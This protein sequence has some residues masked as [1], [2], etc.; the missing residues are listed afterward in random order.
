MTTLKKRI[1][2][3]T[4]LLMAT[5]VAVQFAAACAPNTQQASDEYAVTTDY[6]NEVT[7]AAS[8]P[9]TYY[10][11]HGEALSSVDEPQVQGYDFEGWTYSADG[12]GEVSFPLTPSRDMAI[13][14]QWSVQMLN[15]TFDF[16]EADANPVV[17]E[18]EYGSTVTPLSEEQI[19]EYPGYKFREWRLE[20]GNP[21]N[22]A[23]P[24]RSNVTYYAAWLSDDT[25]I[26]NVNF[27]ANYPG[28]EAIPS[29][30][31][32]AGEEFDVDGLPIVS[33]PGYEFIGWAYS[34]DATSDD[35]IDMTEFS[36]TSD[37]TMYAVWE[38]ETYTITFRKNIP[39][40][41]VVNDLIS[42][43]TVRSDEQVT[44]PDDP[45]REGFI[46]VGWFDAAKGGQKVEFPAAVTSS[47][48]YYAHWK[49]PETTPENN[50]FEAEY[51]YFNPT[52]YF[53]GYSGGVTGT[54][55]IVS[56]LGGTYDSHN[57]YHVS[58]MFKRGA[59]I[60][61]V[62]NSDRDINGAKLYAKLGAEMTLGVTLTPEG[63]Y[64]YRFVV[65]GVDVDYGSITLPDTPVDPNAAMP[66]TRLQEYF[67]G[68]V[69][70]KKGENIIQLI[71]NNDTAPG[72]TMTATAPTVDYVRL[73]ADGAT[74]TW[75]PELDNFSNK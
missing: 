18:V 48:T 39:G 29:Q 31:V 50:I 2:A 63:Q 34:A 47:S 75:S 57:D 15:V 71:T 55:A 74:L 68:T 1:A 28:A 3:F 25:A 35:V 43:F 27:D 60:T 14:A 40:T 10:V 36:V 5:A 54:G 64:G 11:K 53:P 6:N 30:T 37:V 72:G 16:T 21:V 62:I 67:I 59:T 32:V 61:F 51:T 49:A 22:F 56:D 38:I 20:N 7:G 26:W 17:T 23:S 42:R 46:F 65:N 19:P 33:R 8:L 24:I 44:A 41:S 52:E 69:S 70:L 4:A 13:Y 45:E 9:R 12:G 73:E 66:K 58:Y